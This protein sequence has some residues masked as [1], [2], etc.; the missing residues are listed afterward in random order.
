[1]RRSQKTFLVTGIAGLIGS[2][3]ARR[4]LEDGSQVIGIDNLRTGLLGNI[5]ND[6]I[7][8]EGNIQDPNLVDQLYS[9]SFDV[10][11]HIAGQSSGEVS[12]EDP[13]YDLQTNC[14][15]TLLLLDLAKNKNCESFIYA[16]TMSV[17]GDLENP[18]IPVIEETPVK[19]KSF[20]AIGKY[21]SEEY[22][23]VYSGT[24]GLN[25]TALRLFNVYGPGQNMQNLKQGMVSIFLAQALNGQ[26]IIVKGSRNRFRDQIFVDDVIDAFVA[27]Q[28]LNG[29][30]KVYNIATGLKTTVADV[31][32]EMKRFGFDNDVQ[33]VKGTP[34]DQFGIV[35]NSMKFQ[36]DTGWQP[37]TSFRDGLEKM[38]VQIKEPL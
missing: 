36:K 22:M 11:Y 14:Q 7:F 12:F 18:E 20:Y 28:L 9:Y 5:P 19:P 32:N 26:K 31:L 16:S 1:M 6:A 38:I 8:I 23:R 3:L 2:A 21:A 10:I 30:F 24:Y 29:D 33:F 35:G 13:L 15:S 34:G 27:A 25:T 4:L 37:L 17:Y